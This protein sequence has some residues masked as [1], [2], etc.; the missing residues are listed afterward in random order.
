MSN[1]TATTILGASG[2]ECD[3]LSQLFATQLASAIV[4]KTPD[5]ERLLVLGLGLKNG[6]MPRDAFLKVLEGALRVL[7]I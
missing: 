6:E 1:L 7:G 5:E 2:T 4:A 3:T